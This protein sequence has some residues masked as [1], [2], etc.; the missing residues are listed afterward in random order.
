MHVSDDEATFS[1]V[2]LVFLELFTHR[3]HLNFKIFDE[4][5]NINKQ[6][7]YTLLFNKN[8]GTDL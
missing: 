1:P 4:N 6:W 5:N 8:E 2:H 3:P 7:V